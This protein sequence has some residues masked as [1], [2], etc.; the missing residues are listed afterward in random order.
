MRKILRSGWILDVL[1]EEDRGYKWIA[2]SKGA[3][4]RAPGWPQEQWRHL[5]G[6]STITTNR[7]LRNVLSSTYPRWESQWALDDSRNLGSQNCAKGAL[8]L[9]RKGQDYAGDA[10]RWDHLRACAVSIP[11]AQWKYDELASSVLG[12]TMTCFEG[13]NKT[14]QY[15]HGSAAVSSKCGDY[16]DQLQ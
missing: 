2:C 3:R 13:A 8:W 11:P 14:L 12:F 1:L 9:N 7:F 6:N 5:R 16:W 10:L 15:P 4:S